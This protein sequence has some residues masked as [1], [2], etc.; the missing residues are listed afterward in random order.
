LRTFSGTGL[1]A[2]A[3]TVAGA[4][5]GLSDALALV[6][7]AAGSLG[8]GR[9]DRTAGAGRFAA[10]VEF[11]A[12]IVDVVR[13]AAPPSTAAAPTTPAATRARR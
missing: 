12:I 2:D 11:F 13:Y 7:G 8:E 1:D 4:D 9:S 10:V 3:V 6:D 5:E